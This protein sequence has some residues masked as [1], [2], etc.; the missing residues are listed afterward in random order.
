MRPGAAPLPAGIAQSIATAYGAEVHVPVIVYAGRASAEATAD[1]ATPA[2]TRLGGGA[3]ATRLAAAA[4]PGSLDA[5][6]EAT[7]VGV[8]VGP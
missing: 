6:A 8:S 3:A 5:T 7:T 4:A 2:G 1:Q